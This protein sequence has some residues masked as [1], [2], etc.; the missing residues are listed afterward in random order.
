MI[1]QAYF[2]VPVRL[3]RFLSARDTT[4]N[5]PMDFWSLSQKQ[6]AFEDPER[7]VFDL[8][9]YFVPYEIDARPNSVRPWLHA[10]R[11]VAA[12]LEQLPYTFAYLGA[13]RDWFPR[14][15][16]LTRLPRTWCSGKPRLL[17][18]C[19][20]KRRRARTLSADHGADYKFLAQAAR[21]STN[22]RKKR[23]ARE[24]ATWWNSISRS[25]IRI[26]TTTVSRLPP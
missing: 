8:P 11:T 18:I 13:G 21:P 26:T 20:K 16:F 10:V 17:L 24:T 3:S 7:T 22:S 2:A 6:L 1:Y 9:S 4:N 14:T 5:A 23:S 25:G 15:P 19:G 12:P